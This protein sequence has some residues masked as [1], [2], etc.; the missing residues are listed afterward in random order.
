[1]NKF[2]DA[3]QHQHHQVVKDEASFIGGHPQEALC[4]LGP[5]VTRLDIFASASNATNVTSSLNMRFS[6]CSAL[7][8][9]PACRAS[10][11]SMN[12]LLQAVKNTKFGGYRV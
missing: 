12:R 7:R 4:G 10:G 11:T 3:R 8:A 2:E 5:R 9:R 6:A 1:M